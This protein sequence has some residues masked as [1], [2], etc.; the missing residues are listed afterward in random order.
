M[1]KYRCKQVNHIHVPI[2]TY[3]AHVVI[4]HVLCMQLSE[5]ITCVHT[6][7]QSSCNYPTLLMYV[8]M[9]KNRI[10]QYQPSDEQR[11]DYE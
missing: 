5:S 1:N 4:P 2:H 11:I 10:T 3:K 7:M 6:Y 9:Q 8:T